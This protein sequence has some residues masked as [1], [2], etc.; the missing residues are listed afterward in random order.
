MQSIARRLRMKSRKYRCA[1]NAPQLRSV[2]N[3]TMRR[4]RFKARVSLLVSLC[5]FAACANEGPSEPTPEAAKR[6]LQLRGYEFDQASFFRAAASS[7]AIAVNGFLSAGMNVDTKDQ[8]D[9]TALTAAADR[10]DLTIVNVLL[11]RGADVNEKGRNK[12]TAL[13]LALQQNRNEVTDALLSR[14]D[15]DVKAETPD[16]M[17]ALMLATWHQRPD[18]VRRLLQLG[19][20]PDHQDKDGDVALHGA[21]W[22]GNT[23]IVGLLLDAKA[24]PNVKNKLGGTPLMWAASYGKDPVVRILLE[25]GADARIKDVD[26]VTA[27][28]WAAKNGHGNLVMIL[29]DAEKKSRKE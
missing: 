7:D 19:S 17:T 12:W 4:R 3:R 11:K 22:L 8:N 28:G 6:F 2:R 24:N 10:G 5:F 15:I 21:A 29:G 20:D 27:A 23:S 1:S 16:G 9:D 18:A 14:S 26:G 25:R 13:L